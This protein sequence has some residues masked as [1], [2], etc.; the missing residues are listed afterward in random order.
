VAE[1]AYERLLSLP[2]FPAMTDRDVEDVIGAVR[3]VVTYYAQN[4][5]C[6]HSLGTRQSK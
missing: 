3:K 4:G 5:V 2:V 1:D 6:P